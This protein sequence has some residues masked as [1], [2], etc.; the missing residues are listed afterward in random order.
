VTDGV[1][2]SKL[3]GGPVHVVAAGGIFD[4]RGLAAALSWG[5]QA[6]WVGTRFICAK[7]AGA[8]PRHQQAVLKA[9]F[10]D[11]IRTLIFT[12]QSLSAHQPLPLSPSATICSPP[13][14]LSTYSFIYPSILCLIVLWCAV[15]WCGVVWCGV[16]WC[17]AEPKVVRCV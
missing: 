4:G 6:V 17:G 1:V 15:V 5:A 3:N 7:E 2:Q 12:G 10:H 16:V 9:G 14:H 8:P 13:I 11:T